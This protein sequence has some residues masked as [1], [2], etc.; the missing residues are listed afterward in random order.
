MVGFKG[1]SSLNQY[2]PKKSTKCGFKV[3]CRCDSE[4]DYTSAFQICTGKLA[5]VTE[6]NL[7]SRIV[8][9]ISKDIQNKN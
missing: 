9:D 3:W 5:D 2:M 7:G 6:R 4:N 1:C 8:K